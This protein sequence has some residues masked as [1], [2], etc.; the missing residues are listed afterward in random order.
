MRRSRTFFLSVSLTIFVFANLVFAQS[1]AD[2]PRLLVLNKA[3]ASLTVFNAN[4]LKALGNV[5]VGEGPHEVVVSSDG[6]TAFVA[7]YGARTPGSS[8]SIIDLATMK[9]IR[10][11]SLLP[12]MRPH[13]IQEI[14]GKIYFSAETNRAIARYNPETNIIDWIIGTGQTASHMVVGSKDERNFYTANIGSDNVTMI[15]LP[16]APPTQR[17]RMTQIPVGKQ[18]EAIDL[19][20]DG[21]EVWVGLNAERAIDVISTSEKKVIEKINLGARPYRVKFTPDGKKVFATL[22]GA[23]EIVVIDSITKKETTRIKLDVVPWGIIFSKDSKFAF[24]TAA[25]D[26][27][28]LKINLETYEVVGKATTGKAPDGIALTGM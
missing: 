25:Q 6:K 27:L 26:N 18:P 1:A 24:I 17:S 14:N 12:L 4:T 9:E 8:L 19:A 2:I 23:T 13:G 5:G 21:K 11:V 16:G 7:N 28:V 22:L 3:D 10:R 20:P 15:E